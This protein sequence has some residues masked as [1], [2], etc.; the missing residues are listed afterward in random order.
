MKRNRK[1]YPSIHWLYKYLGSS[2]TQDT[3]YKSFVSQHLERIW[4]CWLCGWRAVD[5]EMGGGLG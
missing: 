4:E 5:E 1:T 2:H 3:V